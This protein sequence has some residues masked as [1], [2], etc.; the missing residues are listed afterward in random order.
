MVADPEVRQPVGSRSEVLQAGSQPERAEPQ[1]N[2]CDETFLGDPAV[3]AEPP[4]LAV[5][6][7]KAGNGRQTG[8]RGYQEVVDGLDGTL[9]GKS[10]I[11][12]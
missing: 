4:R 9:V 10:L 6:K 12:T 8:G 1:E 3:A 5:S 2:R 11:V 7:H